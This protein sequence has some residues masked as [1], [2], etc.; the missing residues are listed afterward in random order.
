M[1]VLSE[2]IGKKLLE[3][4]RSH[5]DTI[6]KTTFLRL[7]KIAKEEGCFVRQQQKEETQI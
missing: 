4:M 7:L 2:L 1:P 3:R 5:G 6:K